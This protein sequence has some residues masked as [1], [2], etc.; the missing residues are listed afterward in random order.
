MRQ[1]ESDQG[2]GGVEEGPHNQSKKE[3][4]IESN[5][6]NSKI[7]GNKNEENQE[8]IDEIC[9]K[10]LGSYQSEFINEEEWRNEHK[11]S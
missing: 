9:K 5:G 10:A 8:K 11:K 2:E 1:L 6:V 7:G 4:S 3:K